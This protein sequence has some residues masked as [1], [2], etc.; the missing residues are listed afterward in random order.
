MFSLHFSFSFSLFFACFNFLL[1]DLQ[2]KLPMEG[3]ANG[4][5]GQR[6]VHLAQE[7]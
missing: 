6:A 3:I 5:C 4:R 7:E 1:D 2:P